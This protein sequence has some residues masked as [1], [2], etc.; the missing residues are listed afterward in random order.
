MASATSTFVGR[1]DELNL[2]RGRL[3]DALAGRGSLVF[4]SAEPGAGKTTLTH[5]FLE[6]VAEA[7]PEALVIRATCSEQYGAGEPYQPFV[8]AFRRLALERDHREQQTKGRSFRDIAKQIAPYWIAAIPVAGEAIAAGISTAAELRQQF[9]SGGAQ[10]APSEEA[11]FFQYTELFFT[12]ASEAPVLLFLDDLHWADRASVS[13]LT[14]LGR[15]VGNQRVLVLGTYRPTEVDTG[16]HPMRDARQELQRYRVAEELALQPL[17][18]NALADLVLLRTGATPSAQLFDWLERRAGTNALFFEEL[19]GWLVS[20]GLTRENHG[21]LQLVRVPREIEIPRSAESTIE[22]RLDRLDEETRRILEYASVQGSEFDSVSLSRLLDKDEM[23]LE[24]ALEPMA[25]THRLIQLRDTVDLPNGDLASIYRFSHS[26][27]QQVLHSGLQGKRRILLHRKM[28]QILEDV[29][30]SDTASVAPRLA[31]HFE[32]GRQGEQAYDYAMIAAERASRVYAHWDALDQIQRALRN[33]ST[34][35]RRAG[36]SLRLGETYV[37]I[38]QYAEAVAALDDALRLLGPA[39]EPSLSIHVRRRRLVIESMQGGRS[40]D[41]LLESLG[42]LREEARIMGDNGEECQIIWHMIDLPGTTDS[43]DVVLA[44]EA[45]GLAQQLDEGWMLARGHEVL[46]LTL[47]FGAAPAMAIPELERAI[48]L[49]AELGDRIRESSCRGNLALARAFLGDMKSGAREL[50][51]TIR[52]FDEIVD[53]MRG[54]TA[55]SNLGALLRILGDYDRAEQVLRESIRIFERLGGTVRLISPLMNLAEVHEARSEWNEAEKRWIE[56]LSHARDT[57]YHGEQIIAHCGIGTARLRL[58]DLDGAVAAEHAART[59]VSADP[60][61]I[62][63]GG[64]ALQL[65][66]ARLAAAAGEAE[67]ALGMLDRLEAA[68][69]GRDRYLTATYQLEKAEIMATL[70]PQDAVPLAQRAH[71]EFVAL[72]AQPAADRATALV[73][74]LSDMLAA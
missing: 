52:I 8:E 1:E 49:Y 7:H 51:A 27:I 13:L 20:Q 12:A 5:H 63:E 17:G 53:P 9:Q 47:T 25:R 38:A 16:R 68:V 56:M 73:A 14:H 22:K 32:E 21:E 60:E 23:E 33:A 41:E 40:L 44:R 72:G 58:G 34:D 43:M 26:L 24:E 11:L 46:G 37:S 59:V 18:S 64:E 19:L 31:M 4:L 2:L 15:R 65:F 61:T 48:E 57:G 36:A 6:Q 70:S 3:D 39:P 50:D 74:R 69:A 62:G 55:R 67:G 54:A 28:A 71:A 35:D 42:A 30:S 66:S 45:L 29:Y 10:A